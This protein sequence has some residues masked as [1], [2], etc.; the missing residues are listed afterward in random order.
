MQL[1]NGTLLQGGKYKIETVLGQGGFGITYLATQTLTDKKVAIKEFFFKEY[2]ERDNVSGTV[3]VPTTSKK[4]FVEKFQKKFLKEA[5]I[6]SDLNHKNIIRV[7]DVFQENDTSY[8]SMEYIIGKSL[9][10]EINAKGKIDGKKF[11]KDMIMRPYA[12][13]NDIKAGL[14]KYFGVVTDDE[15]MDNLQL[16][17]ELYNIN[18]LPL[19]ET[20]PWITKDG[21]FFSYAPYEIAS[22]AAGAPSIVI[23]ISKVK[24]NVTSTAKTFFDE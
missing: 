13:Q 23:P 21:V 20:D 7:L 12:I 10:Q 6:S 5:K 24:N 1:Q 3:T 16:N 18:N 15:L 8:Y 2:C 22:Y 11:S 17:N 9:A 14:K 4:K 19:P